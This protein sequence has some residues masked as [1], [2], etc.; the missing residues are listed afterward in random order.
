MET[1]LSGHHWKWG[2]GPLNERAPITLEIQ[3]YSLIELTE[4]VPSPQ[5]PLRI[6]LLDLHPSMSSLS[7]NSYS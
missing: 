1:L 4:V 5:C 7:L 3:I 2:A 6:F